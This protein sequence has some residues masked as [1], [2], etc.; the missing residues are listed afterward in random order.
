MC[1][2]PSAAAASS[3]LSLLRSLLLL[4]LLQLGDKADLIKKGVAAHEASAKVAP[5]TQQL[6]DAVK[7]WTAEGAKM[8]Q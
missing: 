2:H 4:L 5:A 3:Q 8:A 6:L 7:A 1:H